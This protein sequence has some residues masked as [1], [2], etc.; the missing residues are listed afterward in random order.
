MPTTSKPA[1][2]A[3]IRRRVLISTSPVLSGARHHVHGSHHTTKRSGPQRRTADPSTVLEAP[4]GLWT[5]SKRGTTVSW[6][7]RREVRAGKLL[8][9]PQQL[10][11]RLRK[12]QR[13]LLG[14]E[15]LARTWACLGRRRSRW[16]E[17]GLS[18]RPTSDHLQRPIAL[19]AGHRPALSLSKHDAAIPQLGGVCDPDRCATFSSV[20]SPSTRVTDPL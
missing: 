11:S 5:S 20:P 7:D 13:R 1:M 18:H 16:L 15:V 10:I 8:H 3:A 2:T 4:V 17:R 9:E 12:L 6:P 19:D 14:F